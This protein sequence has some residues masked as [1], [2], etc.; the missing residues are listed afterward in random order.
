MA[1]GYIFT[2]AAII[3]TPVIA[4]ETV[5]GWTWVYTLTSICPICTTCFLVLLR[6][7]GNDLHLLNAS[8]SS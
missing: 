6:L 3:L 2:V 7:F 1:V 4:N 5:V 8:E